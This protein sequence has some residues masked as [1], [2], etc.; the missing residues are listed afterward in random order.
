MP[1]ITPETVQVF[2]I[3]ASD[4]PCG[5]ARGLRFSDSGGLTQFGAF[6]EILPPGS[7]SSLCHWHA[8]EDEF[9]YMLAGEVTLWE[10]GV[11]QVLRPGRRRALPPE[12]R[13]GITCRT[14]VGPRRGTL[15][16]ARA[17]RRMW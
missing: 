9:V 15:W 17:R 7:R 4:T 3:L 13:R 14:T 5:P 11:A 1:V 12:S 2:D 6:V 8:A 16:W 10:G